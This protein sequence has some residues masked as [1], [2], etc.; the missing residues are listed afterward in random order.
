MDHEIS[1]KDGLSAGQTFPL[2]SPRG[3][4]AGNIGPVWPFLTT[5]LGLACFGRKVRAW[6]VIAK[7]GVG[8]KEGTQV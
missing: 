2:Y 1:C 5:S 6:W 3:S 4:E 7:S 8:N